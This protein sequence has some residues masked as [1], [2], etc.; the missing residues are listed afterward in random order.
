[1]HST[2]IQSVSFNKKPHEM[3]MVTV[4]VDGIQSGG[5][6][7]LS[8]VATLYEPNLC[9]EAGPRPVFKKA[10]RMRIYL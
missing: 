9:I 5:V 3:L 6:G 4:C 1:M 10:L 7:F 8:D 2:I